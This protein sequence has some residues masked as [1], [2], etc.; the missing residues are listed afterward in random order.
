MIP[1]L[2]GKKMRII[3]Y[4]G[5][6]GSWYK[7]SLH[8]HDEL[9]INYHCPPRVINLYK[10]RGYSFIALTGKDRYQDY[11]ELSTNDFLVY[12]GIEL[13]IHEEGIVREKQIVGIGYGDK[14]CKLAHNEK[15]E[16]R[17]KKNEDGLEMGLALLKK[18]G[19]NSIISSPIWSGLFQKQLLQYKDFFALEVYNHNANYNYNRAFSDLHW[20]SLLRRNREVYAVAT[21]DVD[22][23]SNYKHTGATGGW[24]M[25]KSYNLTHKSIMGA[26]LSG[27]YYSSMGPEIYEI[28]VLDN[29]IV[30]NC[31]PVK[32]VY[33][34]TSTPNEGAVHARMGEYITTARYKL[35]SMP[36]YIRVEC[37]D[38]YGKTAWSNPIF[39]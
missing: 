22:I 12:D 36:C 25:V 35:T 14:S 39:L 23:Y 17:A 15:V 9:S 1:R 32:R 27:N 26:I 38:Q 29:E 21:D 3:N 11:S 5:E 6:T 37:V 2:E 16:I 28:V 34:K 24:I 33:F 31:S 8:C 4:F 19:L 20:D 13:N 30:V 18:M 10:D 7:G